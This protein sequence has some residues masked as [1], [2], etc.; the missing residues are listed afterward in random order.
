[1]VREIEEAV[2]PENVLNPEKVFCSISGFEV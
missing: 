2:K 1:M